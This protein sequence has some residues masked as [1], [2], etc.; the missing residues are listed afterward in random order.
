[1]LC[2]LLLGIAGVLHSQVPK[3]VEHHESFMEF[4]KGIAGGAYRLIGNVSFKH[5]GA[6]MY[7]DSAYFYASSNSLDAFSK[8]HIVQGDTVDLYG[9]FLHYEGNTRIAQIR[10]N[11]R[12]IGKNTKLVTQAL[13]FDLGR[14]V[15]YYENHADI[16]SGE[17]K[18]TSHL[19]Y[20]YSREQMYYF[21]DSVI[22][23]NPDYTIYSDT[24]QYRT[25]TKVAYFFGPTRII[26]DSS[27]IYCEKGWYNTETNKSMLKQKAWVRNK[28][29]TIRGDSLYYEREST[30]GE[31]FSNI[32]LLDEEQNIILRGNHAFVNQLENRALLTD[33]AMFIYIMDDDS[34]FVHADTLRTMMDSAGHRLMK[35]YHDVRLF[36]SNLQGV[37][38]SLFYTTQDSIL[39]LY[40]KPVL[41]SGGNQL[42][43][44]YIEIW[45]KNREIHEL[46]MQQLA[47]LINQEDSTKF[48]Q[49]KGKTMICH[50]T[51]NQLYRINVNG[52]GQTVYYARD[53]ED[54]IGVNVAQSSDLVI[55][56]KNNKPDIIRFI[57]KP[58]ATLYPVGLA[59]KE[60]LIL[61][62]FKWNESLRPLNRFDIFRKN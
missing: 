20:Y 15:G 21:R 62:D 29:Q 2:G 32:E 6:L 9:D 54:L 35:G 45:T 37:C 36:K 46:H 30:Y 55:T 61:K 27:Y 28:K 5:E 53:K 58:S 1:L 49:I 11:V 41:W 3:K 43:A 59:P 40:H 38:D 17:N 4:D 19:G 13:D 26:G 42:S 12:L 18:L 52:N 14:N 51:N 16:E 7:C 23:K 31:G 57:T 22:L 10:K 25:T 44:E 39:K 34:A 24:L 8:V 60:E 48:N 56:I 33:S 47:F 50:F